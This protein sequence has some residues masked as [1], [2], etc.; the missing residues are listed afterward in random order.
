[1]LMLMLMLML[2]LKLLLVLVLVLDR[3]ST[4]AYLVTDWFVTGPIDR[5]PFTLS[6][7]IEGLANH[8]GSAGNAAFPHTRNSHG[9]QPMTAKNT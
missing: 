7:N 4:S 8:P 2:L 5:Q 6:T 3:D 9:D 1:M